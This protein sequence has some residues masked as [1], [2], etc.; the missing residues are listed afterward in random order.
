VGTGLLM[1]RDDDEHGRFGSDWVKLDPDCVDLSPDWMSAGL[2]GQGAL[3]G[4]QGSLRECQG[5]LGE[6]VMEAGRL[7]R[8]DQREGE[9]WRLRGVSRKLGRQVGR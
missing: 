3:E 2:A 8:P 1:K 6:A 4:G 9:I 7:W 5:S